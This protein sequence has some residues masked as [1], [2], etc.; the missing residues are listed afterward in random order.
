MGV[1][2]REEV[3]L[4]DL[5]FNIAVELN[6]WLDAPVP[7]VLLHGFHIVEKAYSILLEVFRSRGGTL[8]AYL[9]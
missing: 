2:W 3:G 8:A 7:V 1:I 6:A 4:C 5:L 9:N